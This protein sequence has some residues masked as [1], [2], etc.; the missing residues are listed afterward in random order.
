MSRILF[1]LLMLSLAYVGSQAHAV[2]AV[3]TC[4]FQPSAAKSEHDPAVFKGLPLD[5]FLQ[6]NIGPE[7]IVSQ[8]TM[9]CL[10]P[11]LPALEYKDVVAVSEMFTIGA[12]LG[13]RPSVFR[14][15]IQFDAGIALYPQGMFEKHSAIVTG[16]GNIV[17]ARIGAGGGLAGGPGA[18]S[19][20]GKVDAALTRP[21]SIGGDVQ[22]GTIQLYNTK[23][24]AKRLG[25]R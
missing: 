17:V 8:G 4:T 1:A 19:V 9:A 11:L 6:I 7:K 25:L 20:V 21:I 13:L 22:F 2:Q 12:N 14:S 23:A 18:S 3:W 24:Q 15:S 16:N 5:Q 10:S